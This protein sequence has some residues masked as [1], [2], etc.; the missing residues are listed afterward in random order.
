MQTNAT[1]T[2]C[3]MLLV[4]FWN[5]NSSVY[6]IYGSLQMRYILKLAS[7]DTVRENKSCILKMLTDQDA[8]TVVL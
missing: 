5:D 3:A 1:L 6:F 7:S 4:L 8:S 2:F